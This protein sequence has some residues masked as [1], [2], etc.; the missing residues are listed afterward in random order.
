MNLTWNKKRSKGCDYVL[1]QSQEMFML[2]FSILYGMMLNSVAGLGAFPFTEALIGKDV[3]DEGIKKTGI[4]V[5]GSKT[6]RRLILAIVILN[7]LPFSYFAVCFQNMRFIGKEISDTPLTSFL[8]IIFIGFLSLGTYAFYRFFLGFA[9]LNPYGDPVFYTPY[10]KEKLLEKRNMFPSLTMGIV[11]GIVYLVPS[12]FI[13]LLGALGLS[14]N[15][16]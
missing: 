11:S 7:L 14:L 10:E 2:F 4:W 6:R 16:I 15:P 5:K 1:V 12:I 13:L 3:V 9:L 8:Q